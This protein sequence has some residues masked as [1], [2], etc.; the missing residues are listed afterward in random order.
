MIFST[1]YSRRKFTRNRGPNDYGCKVETT[2]RNSFIPGQKKRRRQNRLV[3]LKNSHGQWVD[4]SSC[5]QELIYG[6]FSDLFS[7][8][9]IY[10]ATAIED[11]PEL[12][13]AELNDKLMASVE[14][15]EVRKAVFDMH[16]DK[17]SGPDGFNP[18]FC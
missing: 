6:Y 10:S 1:F 7:S 12:I 13:T 8:S 16:S 2:I 11:F 5:L 17:S 4:W 14:L 15:A 3:A 9:S 18:C